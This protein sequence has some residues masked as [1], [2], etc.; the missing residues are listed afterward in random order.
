[1]STIGLLGDHPL[2]DRSTYR[3]GHRPLALGGQ[4]EVFPAEHKPTGTRVAFKRRM[5]WGVDAVARMRREIE[6]GQLNLTSDHIMPILDFSRRHDW[7]VMPLAERNA[8]DSHSLLSSEVNLRTLVLAVCS[9]LE[10]AHEAGWLHRDLKPANLLL[11]DGRWTVADW[12]FGRR[13][14]G[15]TTSTGRTTQDR[16]LGTEGFAAPE[17]S[18]DAHEAT[19]SSDFYSLGQIIRWAR[20]AGVQDK[21]AQHLPEDEPWR[22]IVAATTKTNPGARPQNADEFRDLLRA[23]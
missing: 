20:T 18:I 8:E 12:G 23:V 7:F 13:P 17:Q 3:L 6:F 21:N 9:A 22:S 16:L 2:H 5:S 1:M 11:L 4:A 10:S 14:R 15:D 19:P